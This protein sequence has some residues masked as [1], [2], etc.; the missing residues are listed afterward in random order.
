MGSQGGSQ[1]EI[2]VLVTGFGPFRE[3]Y[4]VNPSYEIAR[5][6]PEYLPPRRAKDPSAR[7]DVPAEQTAAVPDVPVRIVVHPEPIH[8]GYRRV[9]ELVPTFWD[10]ADG[11]GRTE[12]DLAVHIGMAGPRP[13]YQIER[14]GHRQGYKSKDVDGKMLADEDEGGHGSE[15]VWYGCPDELESDLDMVDVLGRWQGLSP[16]DA[17]LRISDDAGHYLCDFIYYSSLAHLW[18][19]Q[20]PRKLTFLHVPADASERNVALGRELAVNLI[21]AM[22]DSE[23][24]RRRMEVAAK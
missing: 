23:L 15:W 20:R 14:R 3:Q 24:G 22:V 7:S 4:P 10:R 19:Q 11:G 21:R 12:Y 16:K 6:L 5:R 9:R 2:R 17:D 18:K 1:E 8:V 13:H